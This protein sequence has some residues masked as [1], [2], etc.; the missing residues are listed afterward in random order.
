MTS[1]LPGN[2]ARPGAWL[3]GEQSCSYILL[4]T[5]PARVEEVE[6]AG[7]HARDGV[8]EAV[9]GH[10]QSIVVAGGAL[11]G[12][13]LCPPA[14][15]HQRQEPARCP[16]VDGGLHLVRAQKER[17]REVLVKGCCL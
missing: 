3:G 12:L 13:R 4:V 9:P 10:G 6:V 2:A 11:L 17:S 5:H 14:D 8:H 15:A 1:M 16:A 7:E